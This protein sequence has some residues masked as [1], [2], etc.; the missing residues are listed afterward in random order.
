[1]DH[2]LDGLKQFGLT[3]AGIA[4]PVLIVLL[5]AAAKNYSAKMKAGWKR[6]VVESLAKAAE[7]IYGPGTGDLKRDY[8]IRQAAAK[9]LPVTNSDIEAAV[10]DLK[11]T[12][13]AAPAVPP[14]KK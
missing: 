3:A 6:D 1:M 12:M 11:Q 2:I 13:C 8:V 10:Y 5:I 7:Q 4:T 14:K 9:K